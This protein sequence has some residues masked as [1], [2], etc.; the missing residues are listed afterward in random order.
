MKFYVYIKI[1]YFLAI[2][3]LAF[4]CNLRRKKKIMHKFTQVIDLKYDIFLH[5]C[6]GGNKYYDYQINK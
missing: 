5:V 4:I 3:T 1:N 6:P 2:S